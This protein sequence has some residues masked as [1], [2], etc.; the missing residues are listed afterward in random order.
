MA[1]QKIH[2]I[3]R[4]RRLTPEEV[5]RD[6]EIRRRVTEE[7]PPGPSSHDPSGPLTQALREAIR[8]C[9]KSV[10]QIAKAANVSQIVISR[11]L[12]GERDIRMETADRLATVLGLNLGAGET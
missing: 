7:F 2:R 3:S 5:A 9:D 8:G 12:S 4:T 6:Q 11:F 10:Y 1:A